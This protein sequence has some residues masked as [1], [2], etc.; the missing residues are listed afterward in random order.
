[1]EQINEMK[2]NMEQI[3]EMKKKIEE[4]QLLLERAEKK[5]AVLSDRY[6]K[7]ESNDFFKHVSYELTREE[8]DK[9][10][11]EHDI[12]DW[13]PIHC[14]LND[15]NEKAYRDTL[16]NRYCGHGTIPKLGL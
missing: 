5:I 1:M 12:D 7:L 13:I 14:K 3:N 11:A 8:F 6:M 2:K 15:Y 10:L 9:E 16:W 4:N